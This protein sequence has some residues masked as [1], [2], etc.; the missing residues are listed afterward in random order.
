MHNGFGRAGD[1]ETRKFQELTVADDLLASVC[2][3][4]MHAACMCQLPIVAA[5][6]S[7]SRQKRGGWGPLPLGIL[8]RRRK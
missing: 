3:A 8:G 1:E 7:R 5:T 2:Y 4:L 6:P